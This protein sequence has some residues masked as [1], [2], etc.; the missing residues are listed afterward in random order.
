MNN[1]NDLIMTVLIAVVF[2]LAMV[3]AL[4]NP[5]VKSLVTAFSNATVTQW[6]FLVLSSILFLIGIY[7]VLTRKNL[8]AVLMSVEIM[9]NSAMLN[10]VTF[11]AYSSNPPNVQGHLFALF[12]V[13][14]AAAEVAVGL[15]IFINVFRS[16]GGVKPDDLME[17]TL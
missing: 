8:I 16:K 9:L 13:A 4:T 6:H 5:A 14:I 10:F 2:I 12:I 15:A 1:R 17:M 7:G 3:L 11:A